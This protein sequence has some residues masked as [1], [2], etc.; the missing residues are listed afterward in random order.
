MLT[1]EDIHE[2]KADFE[3]IQFH[4]AAYLDDGLNKG[5]SEDEK[6]GYALEAMRLMES[7]LAKVHEK[8]GGHTIQA[9]L[10]RAAEI[11]KGEGGKVAAGAGALAGAIA[12]LSTTGLGGFGVVAGGT[13]MGI[14]GATGAAVASGGV[15]LAGGAALYLVYRGGSAALSTDA[16]KSAKDRTRRVGKS[17][18]DRTG[19]FL[20]G[21]GDRIQDGE[22][23]EASS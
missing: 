16:G 9:V 15:A 13:G 2:F 3:A 8:Q 11:A 21:L 6:A 14:A 4:L 19:R 23:D 22:E 1:P 12:S 7:L 17:V 5:L 20:S 10:S 18:K